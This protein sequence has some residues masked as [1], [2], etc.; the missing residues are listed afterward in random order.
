MN[1]NNLNDQDLSGEVLQAILKTAVNAII[2]INEE[3][4]VLSFNPSAE[5]MFGFK[6]DEV[7]NNNITI[8]MPQPYASEHDGYIKHYLQTKEAHVIG[9]GRELT[10]IKKDGSEFPIWLSVSEVKVD[11][12]FIF[13]GV[14]EDISDKKAAALKLKFLS[15]HDSITELLNYTAFTQKLKRLLK[16]HKENALKLIKINNFSDIQNS[17]GI[18]TGNKLLKQ[19]TKKLISC[20]RSEDNITRKT[21]GDVVSYLGNAT[22]AVLFS[23]NKIKSKNLETISQRIMNQLTAPT[24]V[25][26]QTIYPNVSIGISE[27]Y[28][29]EEYNEI[30]KSADIALSLAIQKANNNY[31][32][33]TQEHKEKFMREVAVAQEIHAAFERDEFYLVYQPQI[34]AKTKAIVGMEVLIRWDS[35]LFGEVYPDEFVPIAER[36][37]LMTE[38]DKRTLQVACSQLTRWKKMGYT[39]S[40]QVS[41]NVLPEDLLG[42]EFI[43]TL[44]KVLKEN[45]LQPKDLEFEFLE[46]DLMGDIKNVLPSL[47]KLSDMGITLAI[48]DFGTGHS[49]LSRLNLLPIDILKID[50]SFILGIGTEE[51]ES[52]IRIILQLAKLLNLKVVAEGVE[53][54]EQL[55]FLS[56]LDCN[57]IQG[58]YFSKPLKAKEMTQLLGTQEKQKNSLLMHIQSN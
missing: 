3:G 34:D 50:R 1:G 20:L 32:F 7:V 37:G 39:G 54:Q 21:E 30:F 38:I 53:T 12:A 31:S 55:D 44:K 42:E 25:D 45:K 4:I 6:S 49:S 2:I 5:S 41:I 40:C 27:N 18:W 47:Q 19:L 28:L 15:D 46:S 57:T 33:F 16:T 8:L 48:D 23:S 56:N 58:Y 10:A 35:S 9:V 43:N 51:A 36:E 26:N 13:A 29:G 24:S 52:I 11:G 14:I 22:F 17:Y